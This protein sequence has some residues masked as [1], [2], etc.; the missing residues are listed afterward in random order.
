MA[1]SLFQHGAIRTTE[2]KA[3]ELRKFVERLI[4]IA[5]KGTLY[6]RRRVIAEMRDRAMADNDGEIQDQSV[7]QKLFS[8][9]APR[10]ANRAGGYTRIIHLAERRIG[11]AGSQVLLQLVEETPIET[12]ASPSTSSRR[13]ARA[14]KRRKMSA[15][16]TPKAQAAVPAEA[17][18]AEEPKAEGEQAKE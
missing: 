8:E 14:D 1:Q 12:P 13:K 9:V 7:V 16:Q 15:G 4:T 6:A 2:P 5:K 10:Y 11:D 3:K 18:P 17:A